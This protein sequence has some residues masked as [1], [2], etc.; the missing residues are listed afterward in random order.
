MHYLYFIDIFYPF[1]YLFVYWH[2]L[3]DLY[4]QG[5]ENVVLWGS[6]GTRK[7]MSTKFHE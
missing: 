6:I 2:I 3:M 5:G 1:L 4:V 7:S